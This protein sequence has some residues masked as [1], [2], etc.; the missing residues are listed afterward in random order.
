M[1]LSFKNLKGMTTWHDM[2]VT[3]W[4]T[5]GAK[6]LHAVSHHTIQA[7]DSTRMSRTVEIVDL[8]SAFLDVV[9]S[10]YLTRSHLT[11]K[12]CKCLHIGSH[13]DCTDAY[14][15]ES[16]SPPP[17]TFT[18]PKQHTP[19]SKLCKHR[20]EHKV[21]TNYTCSLLQ[22]GFSVFDPRLHWERRRR[23]GI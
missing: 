21:S 8:R 4:H 2:A 9:R 20:Y 6:I 16:S 1:H 7:P 18:L 23:V 12:G 19:I 3:R 5:M 22:E 15:S 14:S 10:E 11:R 13:E 17:E